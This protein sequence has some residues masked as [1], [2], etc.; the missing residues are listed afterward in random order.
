MAKIDLDNM[1]E[2]IKNTQWSLSSPITRPPDHRL[3]DCLMKN[4]QPLAQQQPPAD[5]LIIGAGFAGLDE[6]E[7]KKIHSAAW[8][9]DY[10]LKGKRIAVIGTGAS[11]VQIVPELAKCAGKLT[12][13]Q[14][15][16]PWIMP[17]PDFTTPDWN[18]TLFRK[19]PV[20]QTAVRKA[21]YLA[22]ESMALAVI[23]NSPLTRFAERLGRWHLRKQVPDR[24]LRR[25]LTPDY[26][27]L[28]EEAASETV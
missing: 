28:A 23:W 19:A 21:L 12:V 20:S 22:H 27:L 8:D 15:T 13:F 4:N 14:R 16:P 11:A 24:W 17:R 9:H 26:R 6:F 25:Q 2:K 10:D 3:R 5:A 1:L 18:K 7:G